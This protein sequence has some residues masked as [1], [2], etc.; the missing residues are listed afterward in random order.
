MLM[1]SIK[2]ALSLSYL[3]N[4]VNIFLSDEE[5]NEIVNALSLIMTENEI[6]NYIN[7]VSELHKNTFG[8]NLYCKVYPPP[9]LE[10][11]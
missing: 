11:Y 1:N 4:N 6:E 9:P 10:E 5:I 2:L 8:I 3:P 7:I